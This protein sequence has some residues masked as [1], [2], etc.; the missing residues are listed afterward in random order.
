[1]HFATIIAV[2]LSLIAGISSFYALKEIREFAQLE[3]NLKNT[4]VK[5][6][7]IK[8]QSQNI[9]TMI[10]NQWQCQC[11]PPKIEIAPQDDISNYTDSENT[12]SAADKQ[13][14]IQEYEEQ[15]TQES[16]KEQLDKAFEQRQT[17]VEQK[18]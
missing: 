8:Q 3:K 2:I 14:D 1:M 12:E 15:E 7:Q 13:Q 9:H 5:E 16:I 4:Q 17:Q 18:E 10:E 11:T 6:E